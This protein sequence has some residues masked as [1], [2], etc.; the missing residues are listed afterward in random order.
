MKH[1]HAKTLSSGKSSPS[2]HHQEGYEQIQKVDKAMGNAAKKQA[3][4]RATTGDLA[5][6]LLKDQNPHLMNSFMDPPPS[7]P[8]NAIAHQLAGYTQAGTKFGPCVVK[9]GTLASAELHFA[10]KSLARDGQCETSFVEME[11]GKDILKCKEAECHVELLHEL[12]HSNMEGYV[13]TSHEAVWFKRFLSDQSL[14]E[15]KDN[16]DFNW[17][18]YLNDLTL[19]AT[20][21]EQLNQLE[22]H[23]EEHRL[24]LSK[25]ELAQELK[26]LIVEGAFDMIGLSRLNPR[27]PSYEPDKFV[28]SSLLAKSSPVTANMHDAQGP[29]PP[30]SFAEPPH[31]FPNMTIH[32]LMTWMNTGSH[33]KSQ[34]KVMHLIREVI[35]AEDFDIKDLDGFSGTVGF[36]DNWVETEVNLDIPTKSKDDQSVLFRV[37]GFHY[38]LL[39]AVIHSTFTNTQAN[40]FHLLPFKHLWKDPL[41]GHE[42]HIF[43]ELYTSDFWIEAQDNLQRQPKEPGCSLEHVITRLMFFSDAT[44]LANFGTAKAWPL[45]L[46]FGNLSKYTCSAPSSGTCHLVGFLPSLPDRIKDVFSS[47][48]RMSKSSMAALH[49]HCQ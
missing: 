1:S 41:D 39:V 15:V 24:I 7:Y 14:V 17:T 3:M 27:H 11:A 33:Q 10:A 16:F 28:P 9:P 43:D 8:P 46:Y 35:Q 37:P 30:A 49:T 47:L 48:P 2:H 25:E 36:P 32:H 44:H 4:W 5:Q 29:D 34:T 21:D 38:W 19:L 23:T 45:Y 12:Q 22:S 26:A 6:P 20:A 31:P 13:V 18:V 42:E 40:A